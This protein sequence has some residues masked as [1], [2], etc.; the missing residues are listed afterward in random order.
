MKCCGVDDYRDFDLSENWRNQK[1][2]KQVPEACC[3][4]ENRALQDQNC[5]Y[6]PS[7]R[8]SYF[9]DVSSFSILYF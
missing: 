7:Q 1:G 2:S 9:H 6:D 4:L 3:K 8:N 5:P